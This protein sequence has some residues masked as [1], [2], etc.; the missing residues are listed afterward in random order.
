GGRRNEIGGLEYDRVAIGDGRRDLPCR[1]GD[2]EVPG[3]DDP[4]DADRLAGDL[5]I[6]PRPNRI[7]LLAGDA[8]RLGGEE[9]EDLGG[10][11]DLA[12][13]FRQRLALFP[14]QKTAE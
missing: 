6:E 9:A 4:D 8:Q 2:G 12:D 3:R 10:S 13:A 7:E 11:R 14:G 1:N 5:D